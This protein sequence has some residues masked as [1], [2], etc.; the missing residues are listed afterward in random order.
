M[1]VYILEACLTCGCSDIR[2]LQQSLFQTTCDLRNR[3]NLIQ[4]CKKLRPTEDIALVQL[5]HV[6]VEVQWEGVY[7]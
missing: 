3:K 7:Q 6:T 4:S 1:L 5:Q 2:Q